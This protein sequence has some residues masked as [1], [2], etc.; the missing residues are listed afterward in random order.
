MSQH[1]IETHTHICRICGL[2]F[3]CPLE[4]CDDSEHECEY[5]YRDGERDLSA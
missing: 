5:C 4:E 1:L 2:E 3:D